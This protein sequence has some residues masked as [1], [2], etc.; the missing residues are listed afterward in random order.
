MAEQRENDTVV[1]TDVKLDWSGIVKVEM[2]V[3]QWAVD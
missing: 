3:L 1:W 2:K